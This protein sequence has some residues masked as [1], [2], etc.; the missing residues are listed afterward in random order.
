MGSMST[1][2]SVVVKVATALL[3]ASVLGGVAMFAAHGKDIEA[4]QTDV[5]VI[6][7]RYERIAE[8]VKEIKRD[9][10][11]LLQESR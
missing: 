6:E 4:L 11:Q 10:K 2:S 3:T 9:V 5:K 1:L 8:D 7:V